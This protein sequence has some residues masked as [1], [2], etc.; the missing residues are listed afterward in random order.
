MF[1]IHFYLMS[2][3]GAARPFAKGWAAPDY[4]F[5]TYNDVMRTAKLCHVNMHGCHGTSII[6]GYVTDRFG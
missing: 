2:L 6:V 5:L 3:S 4:T 1:K